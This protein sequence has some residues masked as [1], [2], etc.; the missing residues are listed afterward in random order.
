MLEDNDVGFGAE[1]KCT[2][3]WN[4]FIKKMHFG[5]Q[6]QKFAVCTATVI[7]NTIYKKDAYI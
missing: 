6:N 2:R 4:V 3:G 1:A 7:D 5:G